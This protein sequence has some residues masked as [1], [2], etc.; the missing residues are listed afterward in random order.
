MVV[1]EDEEI[2]KSQYRKFKIKINPGVNDTG[3]LKEILRRRLGHLEWPMPNLIVVDGGQAQLNA[4]E[5]VLKERGISIDLVSV[6]K[7]ERHK[8]RAFMGDEEIATAHSRSILL[9]NSEAHRFAIT[10]HRKKRDKIV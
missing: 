2:N 10:Y 6:V 4:A 9:A 5:S 3:A 1:V 8:P 7:D